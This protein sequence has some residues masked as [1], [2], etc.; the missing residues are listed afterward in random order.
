M[1]TD[2][3][4]SRNNGD[5]KPNVFGAV[6]TVI[7]SMSAAFGALS[8]LSTGLGA[9]VVALLVGLAISIVLYQY[10]YWSLQAAF[11]TWLAT[12]VVLIIGF[13]IISQPAT[14]TGRITNASGTPIPG[15]RLILTNSAGYDQHTVT[16]QDGYFEVHGVPDGRYVLT[17]ESL[18]DWTYTGEVPSGWQRIFMPKIPTGGLTIPATAVVVPTAA[19]MPVPPTLSA[20]DTSI[21]AASPTSTY[22]TEAPSTNTAAPSSTYT[23]DPTD[24]STATP[25][26]TPMLTPSPAPTKF[27]GGLYDD[28]SVVGRNTQLWEIHP[29]SPLSDIQ[30][31]EEYGALQLVNLP[32]TRGGGFDKYSDPFCQD[33]NLTG[34]KVDSAPFPE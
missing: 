16:D 4:K 29:D 28:F 20:I 30:V 1:T 17:I 3:P 2:K 9:P 21:P 7:I 8:A 12:G 25:S 19:A 32:G 31:F 13:L 11:T 33:R 14:V 26:L 10:G 18:S 27:A 24:T 34:F 23:N 6:A 15:K 22:I 5:S